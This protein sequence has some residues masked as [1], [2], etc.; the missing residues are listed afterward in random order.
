LRAA[1]RARAASIALLIMRAPQEDSAR[2]TFQALVDEGLHGAGDVGVELALGLAFELRLRQL[3]AHHSHRPRARRRRSG[4]L[5]DFEQ[6]HL[7]ADEVDG[8]RERRAKT[9]KMRAAVHGIDV[10]GEAEH[11]LGIAV[12]VLQ[13]DV[14]LDVVADASM[15]MGLSCSTLLPRLRCLTNSEMRRRNGIRRGALPG[16]GVGG[17]LVSQRNLQALL[18]KAIS[19]RRWANVS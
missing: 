9:G 1:S 10:V 8:A 19:R 4:F 13:R 5:L 15:T 16:L 11:R 17:A 7:L 14:D 6:A 3:H 12:V 18:R 2:D